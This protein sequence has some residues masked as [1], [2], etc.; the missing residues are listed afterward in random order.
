MLHRVAPVT[1]DVSRENIASIV[2]ETRIGEMLAVAGNRIM[3]RSNNDC[4]LVTVDLVPISL[5]LV[6][7]MMEDIASSETSVL[8]RAT[9]R[10]IPEY[11]ILHSHRR[12]NFNCYIA[13]TD[14][15]L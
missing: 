12:E 5:I 7:L 1:S 13:L 4:F 14:W 8:T 15:A 10:K 3:L 2:R 9:R 6:I 11:G